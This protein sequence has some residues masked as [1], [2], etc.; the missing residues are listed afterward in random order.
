MSD[1]WLRKKLFALLKTGQVVDREHRLRV[2]EN[3]L[4]RDVASLNDVSEIELRSCVDVLAYWQKQGEL[5]SR[6]EAL[7]TES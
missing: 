5:V 6:C 3:V 2:V 1:D 7:K 4:Y